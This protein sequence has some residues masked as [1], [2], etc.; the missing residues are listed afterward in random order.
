MVK[1]S[2]IKKDAKSFNWRWFTT[3]KDQYKNVIAGKSLKNRGY[4][5]FVARILLSCSLLYM[6]IAFYTSVSFIV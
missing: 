3:E 1:F 2:Q 6:Y 4:H 5:S